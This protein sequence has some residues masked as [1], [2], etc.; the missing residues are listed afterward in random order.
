VGDVLPFLAAH[1]LGGLLTAPWR[2][3]LFWLPN[4]VIDPSAG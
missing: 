2:H 4:E 3:I 1:L